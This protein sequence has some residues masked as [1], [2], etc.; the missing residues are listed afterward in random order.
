MDRFDR[1][2]NEALKSN[3][4]YID[5]EINKVS[6]DIREVKKLIS[7]IKKVIDH[8]WEV[9]RFDILKERIENRI[10]EPDFSNEL[11]EQVVR[12]LDEKLKQDQITSSDEMYQWCND[13]VEYLDSVIELL[14]KYESKLEDKIQRIRELE[15][16]IDSNNVDTTDSDD[17]IPKVTDYF[18]NNLQPLTSHMIDEHCD[19]K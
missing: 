12:Y 7:S 15:S 2:F 4:E 19:D 9:F 16:K 18:E 1:S 5:K 3:K 10:R 8:N 13:F 6:N 11:R 17:N 14:E